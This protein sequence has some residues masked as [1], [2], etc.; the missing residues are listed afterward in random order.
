MQKRPLTREFFIVLRE[1]FGNMGKDNT[2][3]LKKAL[4][5]EVLLAKVVDFDRD[6]FQIALNNLSVYIEVVYREGYTADTV[7]CK[8]C[9]FRHGSERHYLPPPV[10]GQQLV[11]F[12]RRVSSEDHI[13]PSPLFSIP[14]VLSENNPG[15][16]NVGDYFLAS[17]G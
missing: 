13:D 11:G 10:M 9:S 14:T 5:D 12:A 2:E 6:S 3:D 7:K 1:I 17:G 8:L 4:L 16:I 15:R